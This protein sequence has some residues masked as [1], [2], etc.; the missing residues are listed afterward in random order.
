MWMYRSPLK[1]F[2]WDTEGFGEL[3]YFFKTRWV[4]KFTIVGLNRQF[5]TGKF[6]VVEVRPSVG[7]IVHPTF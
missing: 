6:L 2:H 3:K 5:I 7:K 1:V 4:D